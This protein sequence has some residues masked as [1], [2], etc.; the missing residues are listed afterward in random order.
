MAKGPDTEGIGFGAGRGKRII[1]PPSANRAIPIVSV[2]EERLS[3]DAP[4]FS[5]SST[6]PNVHAPAFTPGAFSASLPN[7]QFE[8]A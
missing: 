8:D 6:P 1:P 7:M 5:F 4:V 3:V 2:G